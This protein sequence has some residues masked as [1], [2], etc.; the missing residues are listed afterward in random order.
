[1]TVEPLRCVDCGADLGT[2][3]LGGD[4]QCYAVKEGGTI[5]FT[6]YTMGATA[7]PRCPACSP[8]TPE[9]RAD[10]LRQAA[11]DALADEHGLYA[12]LPKLG[13]ETGV[14][15]RPFDAD[16][17]ARE[18]WRR[19][20]AKHRELEPAAFVEWFEDEFV[21]DEEQTEREE[22]P[23]WVQTLLE[24]RQTIVESIQDFADDLRPDED[25]EG[26]DP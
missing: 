2:V 20:T 9:R 17:A 21:D 5:S 8:D 13:P 16:P 11:F 6:S 25:D 18:R 10:R 14:E 15:I 12:A 3:E 26:A 1:M 22:A 23:E 4:G 19:V 7:T 24:N